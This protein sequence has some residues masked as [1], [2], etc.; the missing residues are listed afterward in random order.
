[1]LIMA[2]VSAV[3]SLPAACMA[4][5]PIIAAQRSRRSLVR[6]RTAVRPPG[7]GSGG[8]PPPRG[9]APNG[10][11]VSTPPGQVRTPAGSR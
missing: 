10:G 2:A 4:P 5:R 6:S 7:G 3:A 9:G 1:M 11:S 8:A